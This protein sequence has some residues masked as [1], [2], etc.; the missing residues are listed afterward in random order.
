M[1][2]IFFIF[3]CLVFMSSRIMF[4][5][6][7]LSIVI[8]KVEINQPRPSGWESGGYMTGCLETFTRTELFP[9]SNFIFSC[10]IFSLKSPLWFI[11]WHFSRAPEIRCRWMEELPNFSDS[12]I[13][14]LHWLFIPPTNNKFETLFHSCRTLPV[15]NPKFFFFNHLKL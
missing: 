10:A 5:F 12:P 13:I 3:I 9:I 11:L 4:T 1:R 2:C 7:T 8:W 14:Q 6:T 15:D